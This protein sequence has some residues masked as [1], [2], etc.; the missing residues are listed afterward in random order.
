MNRAAGQRIG[1]WNRPIRLH[2]PFQKRE[3]LL[4]RTLRRVQQLRHFIRIRHIRR[5][6]KQL[7]LRIENRQRRHA[8]QSQR[9]KERRVRIHV[10]R[11]TCNAAFRQFCFRLLARVAA[12]PLS[13]DK[14]D[15]CSRRLCGLYRRPKFARQ[16]SMA[17]RTPA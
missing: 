15:L 9:V 11:N 8:P 2:Q 6:A 7:P 10:Q 1:G 14:D 4:C 16:V 3:C 17:V 5:R 13:A 12:N